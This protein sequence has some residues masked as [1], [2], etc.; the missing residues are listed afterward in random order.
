MTPSEE[1]TLPPSEGR[2]MVASGGSHVVPQG[3]IHRDVKD[4]FSSLFRILV[5]PLGTVALAFDPIPLGGVWTPT[6]RMDLRLDEMM[7]LQDLLAFL[8][9][10]R[11]STSEVGRKQKVQASVYKR[12]RKEMVVTYG[13]LIVN[14]HVRFG[15]LTTPIMF[16]DFPAIVGSPFFSGVISTVQDNAANKS[17]K[18]AS[19]SFRHLKIHPDAVTGG[20]KSPSKNV[21]AKGDKPRPAQVQNYSVRVI[22][23]EVVVA[24]P[25]R[26]GQ[27]KNYK[28]KRPSAATSTSSKSV[29][30]GSLR[31]RLN[32]GQPIIPRKQEDSKVEVGIEQKIR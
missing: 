14:N 25:S 26:R 17:T 6:F 23:F 10:F 18:K 31:V 16:E 15:Y 30:V 22:S 2:T 3:H 1:D 27:S 13:P 20:I 7:H 29:I 4:V 24:V 11:L 19:R 12:R 5:D 9:P 28:V 8:I 32:G 21:A